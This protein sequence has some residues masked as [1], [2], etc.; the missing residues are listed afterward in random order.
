MIESNIFVYSS[1]AEKR[2]RD[3]IVRKYDIDDSKK[4]RGCVECVILRSC[5]AATISIILDGE[6]IL[7][8]K[9][10]N[11]IN[12][13]E[14]YSCEASDFKGPTIADFRIS[15]SKSKPGIV[16]IFQNSSRFSAIRK[17]GNRLDSTCFRATFDNEEITFAISGDYSIAKMGEVIFSILSV[18]FFRPKNYDYITGLDRGD[19]TVGELTN[20]IIANATIRM[21]FTAYDFSP[22]S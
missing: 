5:N 14:E 18:G 7:S 15:I 16:C 12:N 22:T 13:S 6:R 11:L 2:T 17:I 10:I 1:P 3:E 8:W 9:C 4:N 21:V 20:L 19:L